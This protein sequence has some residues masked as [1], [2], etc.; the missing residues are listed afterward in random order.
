MGTKMSK[1]VTVCSSKMLLTTKNDYILMCKNEIFKVEKD[2]IKFRDRFADKPDEYG[3]NKMY[4][5]AKNQLNQLNKYLR[6]IPIII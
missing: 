3:I 2:F 1:E 5:Y 6:E 4:E